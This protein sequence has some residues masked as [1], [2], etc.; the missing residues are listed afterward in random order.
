M[1]S[2]QAWG[3]HFGTFDGEQDISAEEKR[4]ILDT[5]EQSIASAVVPDAENLPP[6]RKSSLFP[7][8]V[9]AAGVVAAVI[10]IV[11]S[12][13]L[14]RVRRDQLESAAAGPATAEGMIL[15][16]FKREAEEKIRE[17]DTAIVRV[18][19]QLTALEREREQL[20]RIMQLRIQDKEREMRQSLEAEL[21]TRRSELI[22]RGLPS[23]EAAE[24][25]QEL[26]SSRKRD[27]FD[28]LEAFQ[29]ELDT[30]AYEKEQELI[31]EKARARLALERATVEREELL[32]ETQKKEA[33]LLEQLRPDEGVPGASIGIA[34][35]LA[36]E[37]S[38]GVQERLILDQIAGTFLAVGN[39]VVRGRYEAADGGLD[40][41]EAILHDEK[42][43][44]LQGVE[45][46]KAS[47]LKL[48]EAFRVLLAA[49]EAGG[50]GGQSRTAQSPQ[51][52][53]EAFEQEQI[54]QDLGRREAEL[55][56]LQA[57]SRSV[58]AERAVERE[59]LE[60]LR[61]EL[62]RREAE[63]ARLPEAA[64]V[65]RQAIADEAR[66]AAFRDLLAAVGSLDGGSSSG[67]DLAALRDQLARTEAQQNL[68]E[69]IL[70][71]VE[72]LADQ[73]AFATTGSGRTYRILGTV[74]SAG[75]VRITILPIVDL[76]VGEGAPVEI[77]RILESGAMLR[78]AR[79]SVVEV[80]GGKLVARIDDVAGR[81]APVIT[82]KVYLIEE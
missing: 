67:T 9:N 82:D 75:P 65:D 23:A 16:E 43:S 73:A 31:R 35:A 26:E 48:I 21:A 11:A 61:R 22:E 15:E 14:F 44:S 28:Q 60:S 20:A 12:L 27:M 69:R 80:Q 72:E 3:S 6:R 8:A 40:S 45:R 37:Q 47:D 50:S 76:P 30:L 17:K 4:Q 10:V 55:A 57:E 74:T 1:P 68:V 79:A 66:T 25:L 39:Q 24:R 19:R 53:A 59:Q 51:A 52:G 54:E 63:M 49:A 77:R 56:R 29:A 41:L 78:I 7:L 64:A 71:Q 62:R 36:E 38:M 58:A 18:L 33:I 46:R 5:I 70:R 81:E 2:D 32:Q 42:I 13:F 34:A